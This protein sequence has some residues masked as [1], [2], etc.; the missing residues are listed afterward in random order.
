MKNIVDVLNSAFKIIPDFKSKVRKS[1]IS[2]IDAVKYRFKYADIRTTKEEIKSK[3]N[4]KTNSCAYRT[5]YDR[6]ENNI[7]NDLY[8]N[9]LN[10]LRNFYKTNF[11]VNNSITILSAD[12]TFN[13]TNINKFNN[14]LETSLNM[15]YYDTV[16]D[17][18]IDLTFNGPNNKN[19][20]I[21]QLKQYIKDNNLTNIIIV[22]DRAYFKYNFFDYLDNKNIFYVI[23]VKSNSHLLTK[24]KDNNKQKDLINKIKNSTRIIN[25]SIYN[26]KTLISK[27]GEKIKVKSNNVIY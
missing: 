14:K 16:N 21:Q 24:T 6:K 26:N 11:K 12:R 25:Y 20:E 4:Y 5:S 7:S 3:I 15:G 8:V 17:V 1:K 2:N 13:N 18:P 19:S 9:I 27:K 22:A 23:R 10:K